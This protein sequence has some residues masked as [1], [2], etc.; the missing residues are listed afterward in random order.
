MMLFR[1]QIKT[2]KGP[3][4]IL[5][6]LANGVLNIPP[7]RACPG[8]CDQ[9]IDI[10]CKRLFAATTKV[11]VSDATIQVLRAYESLASSRKE[12]RSPNY[13]IDNAKNIYTWC[14]WATGT[15]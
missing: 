6:I 14:G 4:L 2:L 8:F 1:N 3:T 15:G 11:E 5:A 12:F 7:A 13:L 10:A 9:N